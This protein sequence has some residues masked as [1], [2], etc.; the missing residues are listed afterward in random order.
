MEFLIFVINLPKLIEIKLILP[1]KQPADMLGTSS[2]IITSIK[3]LKDGNATL[4]SS[5][6]AL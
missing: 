2:P 4:L 6:L 5:T 3:E 1:E